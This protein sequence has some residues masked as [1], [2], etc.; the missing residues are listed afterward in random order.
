MRYRATVPIRVQSDLGFLSTLG[1]LGLAR[2]TQQ[3]RPR[4][5]GLVQQPSKN[6]TRNPFSFHPSYFD[7]TEFITMPTCTSTLTVYQT[8]FDILCGVVV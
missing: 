5:L 1:L 2:L 7:S 8:F 6:W 3:H 4:Y